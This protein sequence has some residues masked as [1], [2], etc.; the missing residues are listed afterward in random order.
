MN[1]IYTLY[2]DGGCNRELGGYFSYKLLPDFDKMLVSKCPLTAM[3]KDNLVPASCSI[4]DYRGFPTNNIAE[5]AAC[6]FALKEFREKFGLSPVM[7]YQDSKFIINQI[8]GT[9]VSNY[10]HLTVWRDEIR[11]LMTPNVFHQWIPREK[12]VEQL[13]H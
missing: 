1:K 10:P 5:Y 2:V 7:I 11:S 9:Y 13:G 6:Y 12:I 4:V 8:K 3:L